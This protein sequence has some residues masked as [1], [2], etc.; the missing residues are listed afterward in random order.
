MKHF[1]L[2]VI[3]NGQRT[4]VEGVYNRT[5]E[6]AMSRVDGEVI[7]WCEYSVTEDGK[8]WVLTDSKNMEP[9]TDSDE[10]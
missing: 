8:E 6:D 5:I 7:G 2:L 4:I 9:L 1:D 10:E 3:E